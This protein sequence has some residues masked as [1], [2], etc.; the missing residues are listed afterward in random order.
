MAFREKAGVFV[1]PS[2]V[3]WKVGHYAAMVGQEGDRYLLQDPT[4]GNN[5]WTTSKRSKL[6]PPATS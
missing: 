6:K 1:V 4:F 2:V 3:H 5:V